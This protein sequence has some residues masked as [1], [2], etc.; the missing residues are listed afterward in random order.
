M[1]VKLRL[2]AAAVAGGV[3][4]AIV[5][6]A[7]AEKRALAPV[8]AFTELQLNATP[9]GDWISHHGNLFNQQYSTL[10][11]VNKGNVEGLKLAWHRFVSDPTRNRKSFK[12]LSAEGEPVVYDGTMYIPTA[13][14]TI[15]ALDA[16]TGERLWF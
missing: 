3:A 2:L 5:V 4:L 10:A 11:Q 9:K 7:S 13:N 15:V 8:P 6:G 12:N 14:G 16:Q 1:V